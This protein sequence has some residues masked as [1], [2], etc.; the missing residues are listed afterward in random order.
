M[1]VLHLVHWL[2]EAGGIENFL[3]Q[4]IAALPRRDIVNE[5]VYLGHAPG[6]LASEYERLG[7]KVWGC[8]M[9][10]NFF[11]FTRRFRREL[12]SRPTFDVLHAHASNFGGPALSA[13]RSLG[14]PVRLS[15]YH[16]M[17]GGHK[18]DIIRQL[19]ERWLHGS[20]MRH[21]TGLISGTWAGLQFW[22]P[23]QWRSDPRM[24]VIRYGIPFDM[25]AKADG[26]EEIRGELGVPNGAPLIGHVGRFVWQKNHELLVRAAQRVIQKRPDARFVLIGD[27][28]LRPRLA[29]LIDELGLTER[30]RL[31]GVRRDVP[32]LYQAMDLFAFP[33]KIE[34][35]GNAQLEAQAAGLPVVACNIP[36]A[37]EAV[38]QE[39]FKY[40]REPTDVDGFADAILTALE[41]VQKQPQLRDVARR[42]AAHFTI[43]S[44]AQAMMAAWGVPGVSPPPDPVPRPIQGK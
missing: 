30:V 7:V 26:R 12:R 29:A 14:I 6:G 25:F 19:V 32:R 33:S 40:H 17:A 35:L 22:F 27:G 43:E 3:L 23:K 16:N 39:F 10:R 31:T 5:V 42:F 8:R 18:N 44:S 28:E 11:S 20:V 1:R 2:S 21:S 15:H 36:T 41:D 9:Q 24:R 4:V 34:G 38:A 13:A 37:R